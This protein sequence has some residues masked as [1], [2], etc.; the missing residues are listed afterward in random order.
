M[1]IGLRVKRPLFLSDVN[2]TGI[3]STDFRK[4]LKYK[5][6]LKNSFSWAELFHEE[7]RTDRHDEANGRFTNVCE[8]A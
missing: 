6:S 7:R 8:R 2:E 1:H 4:M 5:I 3:L